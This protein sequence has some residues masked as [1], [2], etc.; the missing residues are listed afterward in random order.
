MANCLFNTKYVG[1]NVLN[2]KN[3]SLDFDKSKSKHLVY[4]K[5]VY[6]KYGK[7]VKTGHGYLDFDKNILFLGTGRYQ[8]KDGKRKEIFI[9]IKN[10]SQYFNPITGKADEY[11]GVYY[12]PVELKSK[13]RTIV[14]KRRKNDTAVESDDVVVHN[15][16]GKKMVYSSKPISK[17]KYSVFDDGIVSYQNQYIWYKFKK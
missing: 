7:N 17:V 8:L 13:Y 9:P 3:N 11:K 16:Y 5:T 6:N 12:N 10:P 14:L 4:R 15:K 2:K 1:D